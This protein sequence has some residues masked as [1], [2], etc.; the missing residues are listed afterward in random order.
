MT[1]ALEE[2]TP[3]QQLALKMT[4]ATTKWLTCNIRVHLTTTATPETS[5]TM[6]T[7]LQPVCSHSH[8]TVTLKTVRAVTQPKQSAA[9]VLAAD[10]TAQKAKVITTQ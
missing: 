7:H 1:S 6:K 2:K 5:T 9:K 8:G 4:S 10:T 3:K